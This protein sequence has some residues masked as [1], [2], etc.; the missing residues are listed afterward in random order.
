MDNA[1]RKEC[2]L[3]GTECSD[4]QW[5]HIGP[6]QATTVCCA[7]GLTEP[8]SLPLETGEGDFELSRWYADPN[9]KSCSRKC[10][11]FLYKGSKGNQNNFLTKAACENKCQRK[12]L[13]NCLQNQEKVRVTTSSGKCKS[14]C[15]IGTMLMTPD[16]EPRLCSPT[17]PCPQAHW[18]HVGITR[19][20]TVCCST[21]EQHM[22]LSATQ[23]LINN[24]QVFNTCELPMMKGYGDSYLTR[25]HFDKKQKKCV[26]FIYSGEGG[27]QN[28]F[29]TQEDCQTVCPVYRNPCGN[30]KPFLVEDGDPCSEVLVIG[31]G[32]ASLTRYYYD[33]ETRT[34]RKFTYKG[35]KGN[36]N[37]FLS[38]K[39][40]EQMCPVIV[41]PCRI[42]EPLL[43]SLKEPIIC[44]G[45]ESCV[46]GYWCHVGGSPE[47]TNCCPGTRRPCDLPQEIGQGSEHLER[48]F[49]DGSIQMCR[50]FVYSGTKGNSNNFLTK[51]ACRQAC[52]ELNPC[53]G[54][55]FTGTNSDQVLCT[56]EQK[57]DNCP[58]GHYCHVG[59]N[60]LTTLC[61]PKK[62]KEPCDQAVNRGKGGENLPRWF[63]DRKQKSCAP[64]IYGGTGGNENN[65]MSQSACSEAC[66]VY[67]NYCPH[68]IP[69]VEGNHV[70]ACG[71]DRGCPDGFI[72]H[73]SNEFNV[74]VCCQ[75]KCT[76][77]SWTTD[78][79]F[80]TALSM[81]QRNRWQTGAAG[82]T[83]KVCAN[84]KG[85]IRV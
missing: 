74:S 80:V 54:E 20:L 29:L 6:S 11:P 27:N 3:N 55:P 78:A 28:M 63:Y 76:L 50:K 23:R 22:L 48:W 8:C 41:N 26:K 75:V 84:E 1:L 71:I 24:I 10:K 40:C 70:T 67:R 73:I 15:G 43:N 14:P 17:S 68:G 18:C 56:G 36:A 5:C 62:G 47:T 69:L 19:E 2:S 49:F 64:F 37:N 51:E 58:R 35:S 16:N 32:D 42:G 77:A 33:E 9:D 7:G 38:V 4:D 12:P 34:C 65:F 53:T 81:L 82:P 45:E 13:F 85:E 39:D 46:S 79:D 44:G 57:K 59:A 25:W 52:R 66:P 61:C 60:P 30:G 31:E 21:G 83:V 72:C